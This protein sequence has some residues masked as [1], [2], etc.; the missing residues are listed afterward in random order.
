MCRGIDLEIF[1][2]AAQNVQ[3]H[4][5]AIYDVKMQNS[6]IKG[7]AVL[8]CCQINSPLD[9]CQGAQRATESSTVSC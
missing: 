7:F 5:E 9:S 6:K 8:H 3:V 4:V 2:G 1:S